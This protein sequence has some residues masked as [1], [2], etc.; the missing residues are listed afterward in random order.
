[1]HRAVLSRYFEFSL[2]SA[3]RITECLTAN[4]LTSLHGGPFFPGRLSG[5]LLVPAESRGL[6]NTTS[7]LLHRAPATSW[8]DVGP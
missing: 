6:T 2:R 3:G 5:V 7:P 4:L 8:R 1:M